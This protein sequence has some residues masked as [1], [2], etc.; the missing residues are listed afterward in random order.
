MRTEA[1]QY[2]LKMP[3]AVFT[4]IK[5][6]A[7]MAGA[8]VVAAP[9]WALFPSSSTVT[10]NLN[11]STAVDNV[12]FTATAISNAY[13]V[14]LP[15]GFGASAGQSLY[16]RYDIA[17]GTFGSNVTAGQLT[18]VTTPG[19]LLSA[20]ISQGGTTNDSFVVINITAGGSGI[21]QA[22]LINLNV[23]GITATSASV[24]P[25]VTYSLHGTASS[26]AGTVPSNSARLVSVGP[27][28]VANY[29]SALVPT[30]TFLFNL[31]GVAIP[32]C[33]AV[34]LAAGIAQCGLVIG[35]GG[36]KVVTVVYS[37]DANYASSNATLADDQIVN[38]AFTSG[39]VAPGLYLSPFSFTFTVTGSAP[40]PVFTVSAG[41]L[42]NGLTL[43]AAGVLSGT[44]TATGIGSFTILVTDS[45]GITG[46]RQFTQTILPANQ[47]IT[48]NLPASGKAATQIALTG[49]S[50]SGL[51]VAYT[52]NT[53][54]TCS[55]FGAATLRL[56][57]PGLCSVTAIQLGSPQYNAA[58][59]VAALLTV[60]PAAGAHEIRVRSSAPQSQSGR[61]V[62]GAIVF[63]ADTDPGPLDIVAGSFDIDGNG[64]SDLL[65]IRPVPSQSGTQ[66]GDVH[67]WRDFL[68]A[69]DQTLRSVNLFWRV[70][71]VGDLDGDGLGDIVWRYT[72]P[73]TP[74]TG[75]SYVWFTNGNGVAEVRK[76][77]GAP[78][79]WT[80][81]GARDLNNDGADDMVYINPASQIRVLMATAA[82]SCA[83]FAAGSIPAGFTALHFADYTGNR[84]GDILIRNATTGEV[85]LVSLDASG[86][87]LPPSTANPNDP[88]ASCTSTATTIANAPVTLP[89]VPTN[90]TYYASVDLDGDGIADIVW[91][92]PDGSLTLWKMNAFGAAPTV[93]SNAGTA[94]VGFSV[95]MP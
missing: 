82:R 16:V 85:R 19:N 61:L 10:S 75:V 12:S 76:R 21:P 95:L 6:A 4:W 78:L 74:D 90:W 72:A 20:V 49:T 2:F 3:G 24:T 66:F 93:T 8:C 29:T 62:N 48:F 15:L 35:T 30:G 80:L 55:V 86:V 41:R 36:R 57:S 87:T 26:A 27:T 11:P 70:Q 91:L 40:N 38:I 68:A 50:D 25:G 64:T 18:D 28:S 45:G 67:T 51:A 7:L 17:N 22:D 14:R 92:L 79:D 34:P 69:N 60:T 47:T 31:D 58:T 88:N 65:F 81:L 23:P 71:A 63:T 77:G 37:G 59:P 43:S 89:T 84:H 54:L 53:P 52:S 32:G 44:P 42:P 83:N 46:S 13:D 1:N 73:G 9:A 94:P 56:L 5:F 39:A 33:S